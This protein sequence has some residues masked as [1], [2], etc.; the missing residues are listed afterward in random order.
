MG[1]FGIAWSAFW[2]ILGSNEAAEA[3]RTARA[4]PEDAET[5]QAPE[6]TKDGEEPG[7]ASVHTLVLLQREGRLVDFLCEDIDG[8]PDAQVGAAVRQVHANCR[9]VLRENFG[10]EPIHESKEG[11]S[12]QVPEGF[13]PRSIRV[14]GNASSQPPFTGVLR[15]R[16]WR[17]TKADLPMRSAKLDPLVIVAAEVEAK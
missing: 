9:K 8:F 15:H 14:T 10:I 2:K 12:V 7:G 13:D 17:A 16:G 6:Q 4:D 1:R 3:W 11:D 5:K